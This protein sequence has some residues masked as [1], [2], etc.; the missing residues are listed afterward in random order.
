MLLLFKQFF[1]S[2]KAFCKQ[3]KQLLDCIRMKH[4]LVQL[5]K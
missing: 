4:M 3:S 2:I 5:Y 1:R